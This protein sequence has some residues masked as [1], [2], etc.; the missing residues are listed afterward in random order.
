M[1][2]WGGGEGLARAR[3]G[4]GEAGRVDE[5]GGMKGEMTTGRGR[6]RGGNVEGKKGGGEEGARGWGIS[7]MDMIECLGGHRL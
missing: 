2:Q 7:Q 6:W 3:S 5:G 1:G 4:E